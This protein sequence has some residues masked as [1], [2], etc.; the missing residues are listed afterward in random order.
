[1]R[2]KGRKEGDRA[3]KEERKAEKGERNESD[4]GW[5]EERQ[6][7]KGKVRQGV[8]RNGYGKEMRG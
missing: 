4:W 6:E 8:G 7:R 3:S 1:M 2:R 5:V